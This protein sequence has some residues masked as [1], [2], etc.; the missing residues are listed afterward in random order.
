MSLWKST[1]DS[2]SEAPTPS[3][4]ATMS[5]KDT[6]ANLR[7][8]D[9]GNQEASEKSRPA[10]RARVAV[11]CTR[12]K[13]R[14]QK[15]D[16]ERPKCSNC[17]SVSASCEYVPSEKS[18]PYG[19]YEYI[20]SL[21]S[22]VA[23]L[24]TLLM[25][26]TSLT[27]LYGSQQQD[28]HDSVPSGIPQP[29]TTNSEQRVQDLLLPNHRTQSIFNNSGDD[30][31]LTDG[32][33]DIHHREPIQAASLELLPH[34][35]PQDAPEKSQNGRVGQ[36]FGALMKGKEAPIESIKDPNHVLSPTSPGMSSEYGK[37]DN[38][39]ARFEIA[40]I[41]QAVAEKLLRGYNKHITTRWP[42]LHSSQFKDLHARRRS[43]DGDFE[44]STLSLVYAIG[45]R[46]LETT[47]EVG[48]FFPERHYQTAMQS[49]DRILQTHNI[50]AVQT[51]LL[52]AVYCLRAPRR[53]GSW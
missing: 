47:G 38:E 25:G 6:S 26:A 48:N 11:A 46:F 31:C 45:G 43:L 24:Q 53:P 29:G 4:P 51:L 16:G 27:G 33:Q 1:T 35:F 44:V 52:H 17:R 14:K 18:I 12:C 19:K 32:K 3:K 20:K 22:K 5:P 7:L 39:S 37:S 15:C 2:R 49:I 50:H 30:W 13:T 23:E 34:S 40:R 21:E 28:G 9:N 36:I 8:Q 42:I 10:K 41:N